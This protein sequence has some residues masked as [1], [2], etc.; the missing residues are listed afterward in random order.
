MHDSRITKIA[1]LIVS[2][3]IDVR[4]G[5]NVWIDNNTS[6]PALAL[7]LMRCI[8]ERGG[9]PY[10]KTGNQRITRQLLKYATEDQLRLWAENDLALMKQMQGYIALS[11]SENISELSDVPAERMQ[12]YR[13]LYLKPI[14]F[15]VRLP[16]T[17]WVL[18][19]YP[20]SAM[21]Q[22]ANMS[23]EAFENFY[24]DVCTMD[25]ARM[26]RAQDALKALMDRTDQVRL[27]GPG[28]DLTFSIKGIGSVKCSG[29]NNLPDGEVFTAPVRDSVN[30]VITYNTPSPY[31]GYVY[32]NVRLEFSQGRIVQASAAAN[33]DGLNQIFDTDEGA[34]YA[35]E[36]AIGVNPYI[37]QP[38][39]DILF[40][41]KIAG[42]FHFTPG[43]C[44]DSTPN[45]NHSSVHWDLVNIQ[46]PDYGGGEI[47][48]DGR[49][50][51]KDGLFVVPELEPLNPDNLK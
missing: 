9:K 1:E 3:S 16:N 14:H 51:R 42:S 41:E 23:T 39:K 49:L 4:E 47:W 45:G 36:F 8:A 37:L 11:G 31:G 46:R 24:F 26:D 18:L 15:D 44:I 40:D 19:R 28:T 13:K 35:G 48:F 33:N 32:E 7:E 6:D 10:V 30:G 12:L 27:V 25:Y 5:D 50:I 2:Y 38:M 21:A 34:R 43:M 17:K 22:L 29:Q 20:N